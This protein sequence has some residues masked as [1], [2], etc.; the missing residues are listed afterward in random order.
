MK[1]R[2]VHVGVGGRGVWAID[3]MSRNPLYEPVALV[4]LDEGVLRA[5]EERLG[6]P[7]DRSYRSLSD[8]LGVRDSDAVV[9]CTPTDTHATFIREAFN[10]GQHV[11]VEKAM[12]NDWDEAVDLVHD[13]ER[14][15]VRMCVAQNY[16]FLPHFSAI[17]ESLRN[18]EL[19]SHPGDI[20]IIDC[21]IHRYRPQPLNF[22]YPYAMVWDMTCH[23]ADLLID[24]LGP[25]TRVSASVYNPRWSTYNHPANIGA[26]L[27]FGN[28]A[29]CHYALTND[30]TMGEWRMI[31]QGDRGSLRVGGTPDVYWPGMPPATVE[32][33][34]I[35]ERQLGGSAP[36]AVRLP[37][38][39]AERGVADAFHAYVTEGIEPGISGRNNLESL[40]VCEMLIRSSEQ[41]RPVARDELVPAAYVAS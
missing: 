34:P 30:A 39:S 29:V 22:T 1:V 32:F 35:P 25:A 10:R 19:A 20:G 12:T 33:Y 41:G 4:D 37:T 18:P 15:G 27:E 6:W 8:A 17:T 28:G 23:I 13:S 5:A 9:I 40:A 2:T 24:W 38:T 21:S 31:L 26:V 7:P 11:L 16:R 36:R 14:A 3:E